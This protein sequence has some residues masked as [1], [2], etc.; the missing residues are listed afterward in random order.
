VSCTMRYACIVRLLLR[1][2]AYI[3]GVFCRNWSRRDLCKKAMLIALT[4]MLFQLRSRNQH[5]VK[6]VERARGAPDFT[7]VFPKEGQV[8]RN[9][10][11]H[12]HPSTSQNSLFLWSS[13]QS[14]ANLF[15]LEACPATLIWPSF[16]N[17]TVTCE[18]I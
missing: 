10:I 9:V 8:T 13:A 14:S 1:G 6:N 15:E 3:L 4:S 2:S 12:R 16:G 7:V 18:V 11:F 5:L 17:T